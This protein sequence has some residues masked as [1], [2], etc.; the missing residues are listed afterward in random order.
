MN[1]IAKEAQADEVALL[2]GRILSGDSDGARMVIRKILLQATG[3]SFGSTIG[4]A[5]IELTK[6]PSS[7]RR[8]VILIL[9]CL[10]V[11]G[12]M[13]DANSTNQI[14]RSVVSLCES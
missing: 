7:H 14:V 5:L 12:L 3:L 2:E 10:T 9:R 6:H 13:P 1:E 11:Q 8:E 4:E